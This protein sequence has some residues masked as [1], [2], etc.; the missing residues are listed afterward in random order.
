MDAARWREIEDLYHAAASRPPEARAAFLREACAGDTDLQQRV[1]S[2]LSAGD[3]AEGFLERPALEDAPTA[4]ASPMQIGSYRILHRVGRGG[5]GEV[6]R[7]HDAKLGRD[8]AIK[9]LASEFSGD[10]DRLARLRREARTLAALNHPNLATIHDLV[11]SEG[12]CYLVMELVDGETLRGPL[13][14]G[15]ALHYA[16][17]IAEGLHA[18]HSKGIVHRDLKPANVKVTPEGRVKV[19]DF[20]L[21]KALSG[22]SDLQRVAQLTGAGDS[23][24]LK[25]AGTPPY[26]SPEQVRGDRVDE[27]TD[28]WAF[29][30]VLYELLSGKRAFAGETV[31]E[32]VAGVLG[33]E[34]DWSALPAETP[35]KIRHLLRQ[36]LSKD[37]DQRPR[38]IQSVGDVIESVIAARRGGRRQ[39]M[40]AIASAALV[41]LAITVAVV[42]SQRRV[43]TPAAPKVRSIL[44]IPFENQSRDPDAEYLSDGIA[45]GLIGSLAALPDVRVVARTTAFQFKGKPLDVQQIR[46]QVDVDAVVAGRLLLR[47][48][49]I[50]VQ[51][52]LIDVRS[53]NQLWGSRFH[54]RSANVL[55]IEQAM[56]TRIAHALR[57]RLTRLPAPVTTNPEAYRLYLLGRHEQNKR[58]PEGFTKARVHFQQAIDSDP[59]FAPAY[60]GLA[61]TYILMGGLFRLLPKEEA[62][63]KAGWAARR[64]LELDPGMAEAHASLGLIAQNE[65]RW[66]ASE[67][68]LRRAIEL[69]PNYAQGHL[70]YSLVLSTLGRSAEALNEMRQAARLDP[71]SPHVGANTARALN[72]VGDHEGAIREATKALELNP[73]FIYAHW[74]LGLAHDNQGNYPLAAEA[75]ERMMQAPGPPNMAR[76]AVGRA[77]AKLGRT[78]DARKIVNELEGAAAKGQAAPTYIAWVY[79][80]LGEDDRAFFWLERALESRDVA[81]RDSIRS[82]ILRELHADPRYADLLR[83]MLTVEK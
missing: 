30:C 62:H 24:T 72:L 69:N 47:A 21:A 57:G 26:M 16:R 10:P 11:E 51:A 18:A 23:T 77:Y 52:D 43:T 38:D 14:L 13:P 65:F 22:S 71:L 37:V 81:L 41:V 79:G 56:V 32:I 40:F 78:A 8:I 3:G 75:Y 19:L 70:W 80:A 7:G 67:K 59:T 66:K 9:T 58:S 6:Y 2:L 53:G 60:A 28:I 29:G 46:K 36:C 20:G 45:E 27:R 63:T 5:M 1:E 15:T 61:D 82:G 12:A 25:L 83:R 76:A 55:D 54:E 68:E 17:Q 64:A 31:A 44:V 33:R 50:V 42:L 49:D 39:R 35:A 4:E 73:D 74:Q 34:P 48:N